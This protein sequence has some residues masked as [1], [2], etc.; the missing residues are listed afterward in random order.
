MP[1]VPA[2]ADGAVAKQGKKHVH[3]Y[4][5]PGA[6]S[7]ATRGKD[8]FTTRHL[9]ALDFLLNIPMANESLIR[10]TGMTNAKRAEGIDGE[11]SDEQALQQQL[12][13]Q[14]MQE[15]EHMGQTSPIDAA[16][17][18]KLP[19]PF[20]P[21]VRVPMLF[22]FILAR[23]SDQ[24]A[25]VRRWEEQLLSRGP[26]PLATAQQRLASSPDSAA[27][28]AAQKPSGILRSRIFFS[29]ARSYPAAV[30]SVIGY[31]I[32]KEKARVQKLLREDQKGLEVFELPQRDW[33]G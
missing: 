4:L 13:L 11:Q 6:P 30:F 9:A 17:A 33:R 25:L 12:I 1:E 24:G 8:R 27:A 2:R 15:S 23:I 22:R 7:L 3:Q 5:L 32:D 29:R 14:Q 31:D 28:A 26:M 20:A 16:G 18:K 10:E 19:G 21:T